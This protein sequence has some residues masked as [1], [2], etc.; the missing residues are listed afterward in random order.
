MLRPK[1]AEL[2]L[3]VRRQSVIEGKKGVLREFF[4]DNNP[5]TLH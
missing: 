4:S 2:L 3:L 1:T 5:P